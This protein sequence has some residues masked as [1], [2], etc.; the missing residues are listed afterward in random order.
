MSWRRLAALAA[1]LLVTP[2]TAG[3]P[4]DSVRAMHD[5]QEGTP[6]MG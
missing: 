4:S 5:V 1:A 2:N 6:M 3:Y